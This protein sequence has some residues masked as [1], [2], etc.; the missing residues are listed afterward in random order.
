MTSTIA[1]CSL[2]K[3]INFYFQISIYIANLI[4]QKEGPSVALTKKKRP[5]IHS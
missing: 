2:L 5:S 3:K 4:S 1:E